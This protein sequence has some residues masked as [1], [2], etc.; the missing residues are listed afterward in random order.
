[1]RIDWR[2]GIALSLLATLAACGSYSSPNRSMAPDSTGDT[3]TNSPNY[4][5]N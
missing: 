3:T 5:R 1:M 2:T 4:D